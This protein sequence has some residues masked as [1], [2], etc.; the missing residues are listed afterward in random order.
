[1]KLM[2]A[3]V[4]G[5]EKDADLQSELLDYKKKVG[6]TYLLEKYLVEPAIKNLYEKRKYELRCSHIMIRPDTLGD[7]GAKK[8][9]TEIIE[10]INK[11]ESFDEL[12]EKYSDDQ[13][14]KKSGGD[15][16]YITA[17]SF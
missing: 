5:Y 11:G 4:R 9:A 15:I 7:E 17:V 8:L 2:D 13:F 14:S 16:Y 6:V 3:S 10:K 12:A 1:M